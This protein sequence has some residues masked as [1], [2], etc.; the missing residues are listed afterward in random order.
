M[1]NMI[2]SYNLEMEGET[3]NMQAIGIFKRVKGS[4]ILYPCPIAAPPSIP[5]GT[6]NYKPDTRSEI[7]QLYFKGLR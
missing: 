7:G 2:I 4:P 5:P 3:L 6:R 1:G